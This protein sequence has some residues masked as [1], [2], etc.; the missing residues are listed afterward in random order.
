LGRSL[1][2]LGGGKKLK[3]RRLL[4]NILLR[5][6]FFPSYIWEY[7]FPRKTSTTNRAKKVGHIFIPFL[8]RVLKVRRRI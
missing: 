6:I 4:P 3:T 1:Y 5:R 8:K 2:G 7:I